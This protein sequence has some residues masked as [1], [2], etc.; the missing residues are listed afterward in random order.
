MRYEI[1]QIKS[2]WK[3]WTNEWITEQSNQLIVINIKW[4]LICN[5]YSQTVI[6][7]NMEKRKFQFNYITYNLI[8]NQFYG[9]Y[10]KWWEVIKVLS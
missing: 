7:K 1:N 2:L 10:K 8:L 9:G 5:Y 3:L 6:V 4:E